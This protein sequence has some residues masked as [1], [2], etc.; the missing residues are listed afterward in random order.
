MSVDTKQAIIGAYCAMRGIVKAAGLD[1]NTIDCSVQDILLRSSAPSVSSLQTAST[2]PL[3]QSL[4][5]QPS[6]PTTPPPTAPPPSQPLA[7]K[8]AVS[9]AVTNAL[10]P[11]ATS[12][13]QTAATKGLQTAA[14]KGLSWASP[15]A[16]TQTQV[17]RSLG[18]AARAPLR[19]PPPTALTKS[20][21]IRPQKG[22]GATRRRKTQKT[23]RRD[24]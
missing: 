20:Q 5:V 4:T 15:I 3:S 11:A 8:D 1:P 9:R 23:L 12:A 14:T 7:I 2:T 18:P 21:R 6:P 17:P 22:G 10:V 24:K 13:T 16:Q 19:P